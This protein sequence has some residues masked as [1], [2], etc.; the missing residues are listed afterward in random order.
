MEEGPEGVGVREGNRQPCLF[1]FFVPSWFNIS[2]RF[3][4]AL[5]VLAVQ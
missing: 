4:C 2:S 1:V 3:L 5:G